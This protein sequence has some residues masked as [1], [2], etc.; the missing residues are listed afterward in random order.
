MAP[1]ATPPSA[2]PDHLKDS[3]SYSVEVSKQ[4]LTFAAGGVAFLVATALAPASRITPLFYW[5]F[6]AFVLSILFGLAYIMQVVGHINRDRNYDVYSG[7]LRACSALQL[8]TTLCGAT[9]LGV[10]VFRLLPE[11]ASDSAVVNGV[12]EVKT[13][14]QHARY[15]LPVGTTLSLKTNEKGEIECRA[16]PKPTR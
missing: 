10:V 1:D 4:F 12:L 8:L 6:G 16:E 9:L 7:R 14:T 15:A 5:S 3:C 13:A 2:C 11:R